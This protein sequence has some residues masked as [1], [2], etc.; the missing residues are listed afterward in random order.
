MLDWIVNASLKSRLLVLVLVAAAAGAGYWSFRKV[1]IDS[2]P[3]VTPTL[4]QVFTVS[5]GLAPTDVETQITYPIEI[6]MYGLPS[7][8]RVQST[9]VFG[10]SRVNVYFEDGT[11]YYFARRLVLERLRKAENQIPAG[12]GDPGIG[13]M[14]SGLGRIQFYTIENEKGYDHS[15]MA[16]R[17]AQDW[18]AKPMLRTTKN[19]TGVLSVGGHV[20]QFQVKL[21]MNALQS[22]GLT[23]AAVREAI[24]ANN[25]NVGGSFLER[26]G[27]EYVI[28]G[29]GWLRT[30]KKGL[31]DL[32]NIE[33]REKDGT[34]VYVGDVA[35]VSHGRAI[36]RGA[37]VANGK[38]SVGG[39]ILKLINTNT[40]RVLRAIEDRVEQ[41]NG[42]LPEGM[43]LK[44]YYSQGDLVSK[45]VGTV[46]QALLVGAVFVLVFLY[47]FLG[48]IRSTLIVIS[49]LPLSAL[50]AFMGMYAIGLSANLMSLGGLAIAIGILGDGAIV[51]V[52]NVVRHLRERGEE[53]SS[54]RRVVGEATREIARPV[55]FATSIIVI[56]FLP[57]FTLQGV[58]GRMFSPMAYTIA[59]A[60]VGALVLALTFIPAVSSLAFSPRAARGE[61]R[62]AGWCKALYRPIIR[63]AVR[64]PGL[65]LGAAVL[66][67]AGS[68]CLFPFLGAEF[69]PTLREGTFFIRSV[70][71]AGGNLDSS[72]RYSKRI[73]DVLDDF[74]QVEGMYARVGRA[75]VGGDPE[76]VNVVATLIKLKPL[77]EWKG[78][79]SYEELQSAM[80]QKLEKQLPGLANNMSQP[81]Q[82]RTDELLSGVRA[83]VA[84][85]I[86]GEDLEK[87]A[88]VS[89]RVAEVTRGVEGAVDVRAMQQ[90]GKPQIMVRPDRRALAR[91]G[92]SVDRL[93]S[94]VE[95]G[96]GG[97]RAGKVFEGIRRFDVFV[98]LKKSQRNELAKIR[99]LPLRTDTGGMIPLSRVASVEVFDGP[100]TISRNRASRRSYVQ[101]NVRGRDMGGVVR[102]LQRK[103]KER[104]ELPSGYY[105]EYGGQF[106]NQRRAMKRLYVVVPITMG[107]IFLM[108][109]SAFGKMRYAA[110]IFLNVPFAVIGGIVALWISGLYLSVPGAVGFIAVF[111]IAVQ[112]GV[113]LV[114]Y[115]N[116]LRARG[117][118]TEEACRVGAEQRLR[119]V[120]MTAAT[121]MLGLTPLLLADDVG[122][123]VQRPLAAVVVGGLVTSTLLTLVVLPSVYRWFA[124]PVEV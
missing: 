16:R 30:G 68:L 39:F 114:D 21:D 38:E 6:A 4:V 36:R 65:V 76:P 120:L 121:T 51:V 77:D 104:V 20:R 49:V 106:E 85:S 57:L 40:Q 117:T 75:E 101:F 105:V 34:P 64:V 113:V 73:Q 88:K 124:A 96:I 59:F 7:L 109:F 83:E 48:N 118:P 28:R 111:G 19:V 78:G 50:V 61:P 102:E 119:P 17:E 56:V 99:E 71:P 32:R 97:S 8:K 81:I 46:S 74:P 2:F 93:M 60:L 63:G 54:V 70:L 110:L 52:E 90:S 43:V 41:I 9:S 1:P 87:L 72:I 11:D 3:D 45:A 37:L 116:Q 33:I 42:A 62:V 25:E 24:G 122:A 91:H 27:E 18:I 80:A 47:L 84:V 12:L 86:Y 53:G 58:E 67:L 5:P 123:N 107:L 15:L 35:E 44:S 89:Q 112:N 95:T 31:K 79:R 103:V 13:P 10:L 55:A 23:V 69:V 26:G 22:R 92:I 115:I 66:L 108:L 82:M 94:T 100:K 14:A 98:R 29:Y